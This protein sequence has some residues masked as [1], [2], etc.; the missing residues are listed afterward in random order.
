MHP[1]K[2]SFAHHEA[3]APCCEKIV[4]LDLVYDH[5]QLVVQVSDTGPGISE[6]NKQRIFTKGFS[7]KAGS[8]G[9]GLNLVKT[10]VDRLAGT[11]E[12]VEQETGTIFKV[13]IPYDTKGES[14]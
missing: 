4:G 8:R 2:H 9:L 11:V 1:A 7:T 3:V 5:G 12:I 14:E 10:A 13:V 6:E